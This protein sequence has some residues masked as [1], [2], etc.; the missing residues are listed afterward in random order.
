MAGA[1]R[2]AAGSDL[3][4]RTAVGVALA[5]VAIGA[6]WLGGYALWALAAVIAIAS[7][8]EW[9][10]LVGADR[11]RVIVALGVLAAAMVCAAPA[12]WDTDRSTVAF[13]LIACLLLAL[14][15]QCGPLSLGLAYAGTAAIA[16]LFLRE[17]S[18]GFALALWALLVVWATDIGAFFA[19]RA[20]G[21]PK[22]APG[23]SP[24]KTWAGLAGGIA[25]AGLVGGT[26]AFVA[27]LP[28]TALY[29]GGLLAVVAQ[30]GDLLESWLKRRAGVKDSGRLLPGHGGMLD[31]VDGTL[32]VLIL[33]A[34]LIANGT[35]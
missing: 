12:Y 34:A 35:F 33:V 1:E 23:I 3:G 19:G 5:V 11:L 20:I 7:V 30:G 22:L 21:G 31:R 10:G 16:L 13:L 8:W 24:N 15:P 14:V 6:L 9:G 32:P 25:A 17:Q 26:V 29:I 2:V 4:R 18:H 28:A 27:G